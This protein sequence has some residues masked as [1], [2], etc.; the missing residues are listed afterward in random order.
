MLTNNREARERSVVIL[1]AGGFLGIAVTKAAVDAGLTAIGVVRQPQAAKSVE[2]AGGVAVLGDAARPESW[3]S[4]ATR[5][6]AVIDVVQPK[7]PR[8]LGNRA[9]AQIVAQRVAA[10]QA[11]VAGLTS[12]PANGR[13][14]Y[15]NVSGV[16][17]LLPDRHGFIS[18]ASP[19]TSR[20]AGFAKIGL[21]ARRVARDSGIDA[22]FVHIGT[23]YGPGKSFAERILPAL[24]RGRYPIFGKGENRIALVHVDDAARALVHVARLERTEA[25]IASWIVVDQS[26]LTLAAFLTQTAAAIGGP[27]PRRVPSWIGRVILGS[28]LMAELAK[29]VPTNANRVRASGFEFQFPQFRDGLAATLSALGRSSSAQAMN[30]EVHT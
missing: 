12:I 4:H 3:L 23:V 22:A 17:E 1:G 30:A 11:I 16:A 25:K 18:D 21:G 10:T 14:L 9:L 19:L 28:G 20:P 26:A 29:D 5:A 6:I 27:R 2:C 24:E 7:I 13:P 8:R 15:V